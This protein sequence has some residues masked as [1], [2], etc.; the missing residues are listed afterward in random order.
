MYNNYLFT[1]KHLC[2]AQDQKER[3]GAF[4][5]EDEHSRSY[6]AQENGELF[7]LTFLILH[8]IVIFS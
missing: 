8:I 4:G 6:A 7:L 2:Q 5:V 3:D 1:K